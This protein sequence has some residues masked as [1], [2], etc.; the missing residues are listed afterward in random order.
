MA[1][2]R[3]SESR[4]RPAIGG[5]KG[6][7]GAHGTRRETDSSAMGFDARVSRCTASGVWRVQSASSGVNMRSHYRVWKEGMLNIQIAT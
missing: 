1:A 5:G 7:G 3:E 2:G 4:I 6:R